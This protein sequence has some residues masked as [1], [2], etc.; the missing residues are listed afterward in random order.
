MTLLHQLQRPIEDD[1]LAGPHLKTTLE[2][3]ALA[4]RL[5]PE[6][7]GRSLDELPPQ[8]RSLLENIK[9][10]VAETCEA[11]K[12]DQEKA[13]FTRREVREATGSS[14]TQVRLHLQRLEDFEYLARRHDRNGIGCVYELLVDCRQP[15]GTA[16]VG[17][18]DLEQ[19]RKKA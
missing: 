1:A 6:V 7:L 18:L 10:M 3:I 19:L 8:T 4:N 12:I 16:R 13:R 11:R 15:A 2:D 9:T 14:E 5:A 17:L